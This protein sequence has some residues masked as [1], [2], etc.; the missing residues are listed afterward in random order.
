MRRVFLIL[1]ERLGNSEGGSK[2]GKKWKWKNKEFTDPQDP[3]TCHL[4]FPQKEGDKPYIWKSRESLKLFS[5]SGVQGARLLIE[6]CF[7]T[8]AYPNVRA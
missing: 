5:S 4:V 6:F 1:L 2:I 8:F 3:R 7:P